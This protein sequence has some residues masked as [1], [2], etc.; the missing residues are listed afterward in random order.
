MCDWR[1]W[2]D[3][4]DKR[5]VGLQN[6]AGEV[7]GG[8]GHTAIAE[9]EDEHAVTILLSHGEKSHRRHYSG[10]W[11]AVESKRCSS[12]PLPVGLDT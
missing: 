3:L 6:L 11:S 8:E 10:P 1:A 4:V 7:P 9:E 5:A 2:R 12:A